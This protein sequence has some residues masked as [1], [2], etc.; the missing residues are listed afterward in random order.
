MP[1][2]EPAEM[3]RSDPPFNLLDSA[4]HDSAVILEAY[5]RFATTLIGA[6]LFP[7]ATLRPVVSSPQQADAESPSP[8][9]HSGIISVLVA[10]LVGAVLGRS[11]LGRRPL[12]NR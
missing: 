11:L 7:Y 12:P 4:L 9:R 1:L 6:L 8:S 10:L 3:R 5:G 2:K